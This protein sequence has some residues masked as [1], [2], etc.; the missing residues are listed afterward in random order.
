MGR[1]G[2]KSESESESEWEGAWGGSSVK[3]AGR[4]LGPRT[5]RRL[6]LSEEERVGGDRG[7]GKRDG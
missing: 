2:P 6:G 4:R 3:G 7:L 1:E 5:R